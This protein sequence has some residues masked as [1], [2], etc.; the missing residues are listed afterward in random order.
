MQMMVNLSPEWQSVLEDLAK[1]F[2]FQFVQ[3]GTNI[4]S[5]G[6][7]QNNYIISDISYVRKADLDNY[8]K[9]GNVGASPY[10]RASVVYALYAC[11][12]L[13][14]ADIEYPTYQHWKNKYSL[15]LDHSLPRYWFPFLTFDCTNWKPMPIN[16]NKRKGDD[17]LNEGV[18]RLQ[19]LATKLKDLKSKYT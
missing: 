9:N 4:N 19:F 16:N 17:F 13:N 1:L 10:A 11:R 18:D 7:S 3:V 15:S 2:D 5:F 12:C 8:I 14:V 6:K